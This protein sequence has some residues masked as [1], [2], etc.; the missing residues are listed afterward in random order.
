VFPQT[1]P[2]GQLRVRVNNITGIKFLESFLFFS[3]EDR[4]MNSMDQISGTNTNAGTYFDE[5]GGY[6]LK[7]YLAFPKGYQ[8]PIK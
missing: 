1:S 6:L 3:V 7:A 8:S 2:E 5:R 4:M